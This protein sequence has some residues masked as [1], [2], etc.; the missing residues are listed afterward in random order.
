MNL[1]G[2]HKAERRDRVSPANPCLPFATYGRKLLFGVLLLSASAL[3]ATASATGVAAGTQVKNTV[4]VSYVQDGVSRTDTASTVFVVD[5]LIDVATLWQDAKP[6][7]AA[8]GSSAQTLLFK[9]TNTGN[10]NDSFALAPTALPASGNDFSVEHCK[11]FLD[12]DNNGSYSGNDPEYVPGSNDPMI[13]AGGH[14]NVFA[15]CNLP[16]TANDGTFA[17]VRLAATSKTFSGGAGSAKPAAGTSGLTLVVGLSGGSSSANGTY[18]ASS[19]SYQFT[20]TQR[21]T[22]K[23]GGSVATS[24]SRILYTLIV[25][26]NGGSATGRNLVVTNPMPEH[27]TYIPGTLTLDSAA[28]GDSNTDGDAGDF[29]ITASNAIAVSLGNVPGS[30]SPHIITFEVTIN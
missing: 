12:Q 18:Q 6:V 15:L 20:S 10:G 4:V 1:A 22:D 27:T 30:A 9:V 21:V 19:V 26:A 23:S 25:T 24:G 14:M 28:L 2:H 29:G 11:L 7:Q 3:I 17:Q 13:A 5:Q 8:A 16:A